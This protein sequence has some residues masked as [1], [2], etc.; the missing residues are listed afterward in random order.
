MRWAVLHNPLWI[1]TTGYLPIS[2]HP[3]WKAPAPYHLPVFELGRPGL[4]GCGHHDTDGLQ[5]QPAGLHGGGLPQETATPAGGWN[6]YEPVCS[7][8]GKTGSTKTMEQPGVVP[9]D[10]CL[11]LPVWP[12][13]HVPHHGFIH[14]DWGQKG[15]SPHPFSLSLQQPG[16]P[17]TFNL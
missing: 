4:T 1:S 9:K 15:P 17:R 3:V 6:T 11:Q 10:P 8:G 7:S 13:C 2:K 16:Q 12:G 5:V 14:S